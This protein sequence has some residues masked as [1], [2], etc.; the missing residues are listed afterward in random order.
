MAPTISAMK[1]ATR[2]KIAAALTT[3]VMG[4]LA[5][6]GIAVRSAQDAASPPGATVAATSAPLHAVANASPSPRTTASRVS[7]SIGVAPA[8]ANRRE[9]TIAAPALGSKLPPSREDREPRLEPFH[10]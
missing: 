9:A 3:V 1:D 10:D 8:G 5:G 2:I 4:G 7:P 6:T